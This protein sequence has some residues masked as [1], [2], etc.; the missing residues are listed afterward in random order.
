MTKRFMFEALRKA[1]EGLSSRIFLWLEDRKG[2][3][4]YIF[5]ETFMRQLCPDVI[6]EG[7]KNNSELLKAVKNLNDEDNKYL[8]VFD[9]SFDNLQI[10]M[11]QKLLKK[12]ADK[13]DNVFLMDIICFEYILLEFNGLIKW[14]YAFNDEFLVKRANVIS[15]REKLVSSIDSGELNYKDIQEIVEYDR[16][17]KEHNIEQLA[18]KLLFDLTRNTGFEVSKG[19]IGE[20]WIKSCCKWEGRQENDICGL[21]SGRLSLSDK[22]K[23]IYKGTCLKEQFPK[24]GLEVLL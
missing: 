9:N 17:L 16:N 4:S 1:G 22:M 12:Y 15:A 13:K 19:T 5:W 18:A 6:V 10:V 20:C 3:A 8:I 11:E 2:K 14:I 7:K 24:A 21:D 23:E